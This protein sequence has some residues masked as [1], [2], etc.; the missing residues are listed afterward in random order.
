MTV[1][2]DFETELDSLCNHTRSIPIVFVVIIHTCP[3]LFIPEAQ[4]PWSLR[5]QIGLTSP[6]FW[7][8]PCKTNTNVSFQTPVHHYGPPTKL[9]EGN[10]FS[11]VC[12]SVWGRP[13]TGYFCTR[14]VLHSPGPSLCK[15]PSVFRSLQPSAL[16]APLTHSNLLTEKL[17]LSE[18]GRLTLDWNAFLFISSFQISCVTH[19]H[20]EVSRRIFF[21]ANENLIEYSWIRR[22]EFGC[23]M[24]STIAMTVWW[25]HDLYGL[26]VILSTLIQ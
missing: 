24:R 3:S 10:V 1:I 23:I 5:D 21:L 20:C 2:P 6:W 13:Y 22:V 7:Q 14:V 9:R 17:G 12:H 11:H 8:V 15:A 26:Y 16:R 4:G 18:G 25:I 19:R